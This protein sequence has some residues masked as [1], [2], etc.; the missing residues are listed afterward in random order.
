M[1]M[2]DD[3]SETTDDTDSAVLGD[4]FDN[5]EFL[6]AYLEVLQT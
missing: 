5:P 4:R 6:C 2:R 1:K 3:L